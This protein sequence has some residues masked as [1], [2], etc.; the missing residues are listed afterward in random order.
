MNKIFSFVKVTDSSIVASA[1]IARFVSDL[2]ETPLCWDAAIGD[3]PLD[4]LVIVGGAYAFAGDDV[5][6]SLGEAIRQTRRLVWIQNDYTVVPPKDQSGAESPFRRAFRDRAS[7]GAAPTDFWSTVKTMTR[8]GLVVDKTKTGWRVGEDSRYVNWNALTFDTADRRFVTADVDTDKESLF[9]YGSYRDGPGKKC[10]VKYFDQY[11]VAPMTR[12]VVSSP[13]SKF[14]ERYSD[15]TCVPKLTGSLS[16]ALCRYGLGLYVEDPRSHEEF[17]SP[18][19][20]FY[21]M[22][23]AGLPMI[24]QPES[25]R[26]LAEAGYDVS[27]FTAWRSEVPGMMAINATIAARQREMWWETALAEKKSLER[28]VQSAWVKVTG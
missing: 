27:E 19:N 14:A 6:S 13:S 3:D 26:M 28:L 11:F 25:K 2:I 17:H 23:S 7:S 15:V 4:V 20:R 5:L 18:A 9:Y 24:F 10:R 22:L 8:P 12:T 1:R 16:H 21:E